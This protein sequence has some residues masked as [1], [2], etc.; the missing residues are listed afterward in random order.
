MMLT[1]TCISYWYV[2]RIN[3]TAALKCEMDLHMPLWEPVTSP[4]T[5]E[6][7]L[8]SIWDK[9]VLHYNIVQE[10]MSSLH[11]GADTI[12]SDEILSSSSSSSSTATRATAPVNDINHMNS[13][14]DVGRCKVVLTLSGL[15]TAVLLN[16]HFGLLSATHLNSVFEHFVKWERLVRTTNISN[17]TVV[18][19]FALYEV[20]LRL[21][22][23]VWVLCMD[24]R[25][26]FGASMC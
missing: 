2:C 11:T 6:S 13:L 19:P 12:T 4:S 9:S 16:H 23:V 14:L 21:L 17:E 8:L 20:S 26:G 5:K 10:L 15:G 18:V 1:N 7:N 25:R 22:C 3:H 24:K